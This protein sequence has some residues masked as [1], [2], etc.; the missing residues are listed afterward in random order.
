M[1][2]AP[3]PLLDFVE[4]LVNAAYDRSMLIVTL[5]RPELLEQRPAWGAGLRNFSSLHLARLTGGEI[6]QLLAVLAPASPRRW[7]HASPDGRMASRCMRSRSLACWRA[8]G[9]D[10]VRLRATTC[11]PPRSMR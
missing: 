6:T 8:A 4:Y 7:W 5:A 1:R 3:I 2:S 11:S 9:Q 10:G